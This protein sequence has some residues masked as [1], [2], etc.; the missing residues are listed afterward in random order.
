MMC[1]A[2]QV[3]T[4][5]VAEREQLDSLLASAY[6]ELVRD[7]RSN[8]GTAQLSEILYPTMFPRHRPEQSAKPIWLHGTRILS[9]SKK[10]W[11]L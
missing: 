4:S 7:Y 5:Q 9:G 6:I 2:V 1:T 3:F 8:P 11:M 10:T